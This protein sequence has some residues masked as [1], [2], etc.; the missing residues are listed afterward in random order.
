M[1][2]IPLSSG[3]VALVDDEDYERVAQYPWFRDPNRNTTYAK[4]RQIPGRGKTAM[5]RFILDAPPD[6][7]VDH[8][9]GDGLDNRRSNLRLCTHAENRR[10]R[11]NSQ[12]PKSGYRGVAMLNTKQGI[13]YRPGIYHNGKR[14][15]FGS[16]RCPIE[17]AR[18][19]DEM[20]R[21]IY[22]EFAVL[23]FPDEPST[24]AA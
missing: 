17:A 5:H 7:Q 23:N 2:E 24:G 4:T 22:G 10:N 20:A 21:Q 16:Y 15:Y 14:I 19:R 11:A 1:R 8:I 9:N 12:I 6:L 3:F 18:A 13:R